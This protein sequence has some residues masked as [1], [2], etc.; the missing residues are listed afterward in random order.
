[1]LNR[2]LGVIDLTKGKVDVQDVSESLRK[3]LLGGRG[4]NSYYL[5]KMIP[6]GT[7]PLSPE[8]VLIFGAGFLTGTL[9]PSSGRFNV[10][11]KSPETGFLGDTNCGGFFAPELRYAGF[12]RLILKGKAD[13]PSYIHVEDGKIEIRDAADLVIHVP[14]GHILWIDSAVVSGIER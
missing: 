10:S 1:M 3:A 9:A 4:I 14:E 8:N 12:D 11:A 6:E 5:R 13:K 2:K 7:D